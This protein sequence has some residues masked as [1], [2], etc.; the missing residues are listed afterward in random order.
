LCTVYAHRVPKAPPPHR[1]DRGISHH[2][3]VTTPRPGH[4]RPRRTAPRTGPRRGPGTRGDLPRRGENCPPCNIARQEYLRT[5][6]F[7]ENHS[8]M[9]PQPGAPTPPP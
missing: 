8:P 3:D 4:V 6:Q 2:D 7:R 9:T 1:P 5:T